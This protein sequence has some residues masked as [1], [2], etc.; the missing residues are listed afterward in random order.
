MQITG[1][2]TFSGGFKLITCQAPFSLSAQYLL[3]A[4]GGGGSGSLGSSGGSGVVMISL[5]TSNYSGQV[6]GS[7]MVIPSGSNTIM[8]FTSSGSYK[9]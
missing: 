3:V 4:G 2:L 8:I 5:L 9:A 6:T 7:P 1:G